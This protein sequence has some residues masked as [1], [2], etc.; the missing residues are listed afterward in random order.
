[1]TR[2]TVIAVSHQRLS[3]QIGDKQL[4]LPW[5][6]VRGISAGHIPVAAG[7]WHLALTIDV[8]VDAGELVL[9]AT[10]ADRVWAALTAV[11]PEVLEDLPLIDM[12]APVVLAGAVPLSIY[13]RPGAEKGRAGL[14]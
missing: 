9:I 12:W 5:K 10:E 11:L 13:D 6:S 2:S 8:Q 14:H 4:E 1:M 7:A 3:V